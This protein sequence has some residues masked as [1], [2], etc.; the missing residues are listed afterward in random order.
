MSYSADSDLRDFKG[1]AGFEKN[2]ELSAFLNF[3]E[4]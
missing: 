3:E 1:K 2:R 4:M